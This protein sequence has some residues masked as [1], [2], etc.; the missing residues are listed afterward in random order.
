MRILPYFSLN[1][2]FKTLMKYLLDL[3]KY[4]TTK[5]LLR[6]DQCTALLVM[7][8]TPNKKNLKKKKIY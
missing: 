1:N 3:P 4:E 2:E 5:G 7:K 6:E 8:N